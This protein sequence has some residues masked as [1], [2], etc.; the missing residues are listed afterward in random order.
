MAATI[1]RGR[2][3]VLPAS[4][5]EFPVET[6]VEEVTTGLP[7][8]D[9]VAIPP[10]DTPEADAAATTK[11]YRLAHADVP[12]VPLVTLAPA[13]CTEQGRRGAISRALVLLQKHGHTR[14]ASTLSTIERTLGSAGDNAQTTTCI[15][16]DTVAR[17]APFF[18]VGAAG[19]VSEALRREHSPI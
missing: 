19:E 12:L 14:N 4:E 16:T 18:K 15:A 8:P 3:P 13:A 17:L 5:A 6:R 1:A 10:G 9:T 11:E 2:V 7:G